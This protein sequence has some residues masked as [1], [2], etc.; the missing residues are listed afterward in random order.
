MTKKV[1]YLLTTLSDRTKFAMVSIGYLL[2][3]P[4]YLACFIVSLF[5][6]LY[7]LSFFKNGSSNFLLLFSGISFGAKMELRGYHDGLN[8]AMEQLGFDTV[9]DRV[10]AVPDESAEG[11]DP[12]DLVHFIDAEVQDQPPDIVAPGFRKRAFPADQHAFV[13]VAERFYG[14]TEPLL[15]S[16]QAVQHPVKPG[17][18]PVQPFRKPLRPAAFG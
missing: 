7:V 9:S 14:G 4:K 18:L 8:D 13:S 6:F 5:L 10:Y 16:V 12:A 11:Y 15:H 3:Q 2:R 17:N 1:K